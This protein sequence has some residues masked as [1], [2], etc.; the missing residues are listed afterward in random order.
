M[1][2]VKKRVRAKMVQVLQQVWCQYRHLEVMDPVNTSSKYQRIR[3][4]FSCCLT[5]GTSWI[6]RYAVQCLCVCYFIWWWWWWLR[7]ATMI[8]QPVI[9]LWQS[10]GLCSSVIEDSVFLRYDAV[11]LGNLF[12]MFWSNILHLSQVYRPVTIK[13]TLSLIVQEYSHCTGQF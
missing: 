8:V 7:D 5:T 10:W 4:V 12:L 6:M 2:H 9:E 11:W 3:C 13:I 1:D